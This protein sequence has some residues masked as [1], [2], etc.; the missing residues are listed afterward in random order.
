MYDDVLEES[1]LP[2][3]RFLWNYS[4]HLSEDTVSQPRSEQST[5]FWLSQLENRRCLEEKNKSF[6]YLDWQA[7]F[8]LNRL[9]LHKFL[10][11]LVA[12]CDKR[13]ILTFDL[14]HE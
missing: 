7:S 6:V 11:F 5:G 14:F 13:V 1:A 9:L 3:M 10:Y 2:V 4:L 8:K 12:F